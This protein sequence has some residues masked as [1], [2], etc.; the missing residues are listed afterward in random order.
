MTDQELANQYVAKAIAEL[1][2]FSIEYV[3]KLRR[4]GE[5]V[6][7]GAFLTSNV[8]GDEFALACDHEVAGRTLT[9]EDRASLA[10]MGGLFSAINAHT[11]GPRHDH[12]DI[13]PSPLPG[14]SRQTR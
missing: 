11:V 5:E 2:T 14:Q 6:G 7:D 1:P 12:H 10:T 3:D 13:G 8:T 4:L 9:A